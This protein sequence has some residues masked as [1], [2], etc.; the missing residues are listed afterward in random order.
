[1]AQD[2]QV[3][4]FAVAAAPAPG[5]GRIGLCRLPGRSGDLGGDLDAALAFGAS[6]IVSMTPL[7]ELEAKGAAALPVEAARRGI[8]WRHFP[9]PDYGAPADDA[10]WSALAAELHGILDAGGAALLHCAGGKGR[11]G[12][13]AMRLLVERGLAPD[14][15]LARLR[16]VR[17]GAVETQEQESWAARGSA[18]AHRSGAPEQR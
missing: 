8:A 9:I 16:A 12:M 3:E 6:M 17:P 5:G 18:A 15:A 10:L 2:G 14:E 11:S 1:M 7:D 13:A 4:P